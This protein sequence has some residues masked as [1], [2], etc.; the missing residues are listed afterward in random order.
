MPVCVCVLGEQVGE[1]I[2]LE[3]WAVKQLSETVTLAKID[4]MATQGAVH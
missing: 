4:E 3:C 1:R 2:V